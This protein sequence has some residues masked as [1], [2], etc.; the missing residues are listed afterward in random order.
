MGVCNQA[1]NL[2]LDYQAQ[3]ERRKAVFELNEAEKILLALYLANPYEPEAFF[4]YIQI[5]IGIIFW[6]NETPFHSVNNKATMNAVTGLWLNGYIRDTGVKHSNFV[7]TG[8]GFAYAEY[9]AKTI[10]NA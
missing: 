9:I 7:L 8:K 3:M 4:R 2:A 1:L 6:V 10:I 5:T